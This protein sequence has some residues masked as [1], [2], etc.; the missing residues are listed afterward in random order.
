[1]ATIYSLLGVR[2]CKHPNV[3]IICCLI[4]DPLENKAYSLII[5]YQRS[6]IISS[7]ELGLTELD[8]APRSDPAL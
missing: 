7:P 8:P 6:N 2:A 5:K 3:Y 1:M 4:T